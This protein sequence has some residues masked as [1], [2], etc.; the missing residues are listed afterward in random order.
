MTFTEESLKNILIAILTFAFLPGCIN[1]V[2]ERTTLQ[3]PPFASVAM[4]GN[5]TDATRCVGRYWQNSTDH[6][7]S[8]VF[9]SYDVYT[10]SYQVRVASPGGGNVVGLVIDFQEQSGKTMA[11]AHIHHAFSDDAPERTETLKA[12]DACKLP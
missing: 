10:D 12:L 3:E 8:G 5:I 9:G 2:N 6:L 7:Y 1:I 4:R 11:F